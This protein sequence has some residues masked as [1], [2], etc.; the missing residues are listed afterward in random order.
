[1]FL[2]EEFILKLAEI[3]ADGLLNVAFVKLVRNF[4][5]SSF[6]R[7]YISYEYLSCEL[8]YKMSV[9]HARWGHPWEIVLFNYEKKYCFFDK[10]SRRKILARFSIFAFITAIYVYVLIKLSYKL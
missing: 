9:C 4:I 6:P 8:F 7:T 5:S 1:M 3:F 10:I 2:K